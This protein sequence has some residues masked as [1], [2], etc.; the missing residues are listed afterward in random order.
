MFKVA[1]YKFQIKKVFG[2]LF[3]G[4][5]LVVLGLTGNFPIGIQGILM[6]I[7]CWILVSGD[8]PA[9]YKADRTLEARNQSLPT[10][11]ST[12]YNDFVELTGEGHMKLK[13]SNFKY[14]L[15]EHEYF[16]LFIDKDSVCMIDSRTLQP[17]NIEKF[18]IFV[19]DKTNLEWKQRKTLLNMSLA[20]LLQLWKK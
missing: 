9:R 14:L 15:E 4:A 13:Y 20:D 18:K 7:G 10:I 17:N 12:F 5:V 8:F 6:M 3:V 19:S 1:Y 16:F 2:W 11:I